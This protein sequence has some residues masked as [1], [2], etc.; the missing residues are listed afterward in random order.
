MENAQ[1]G[2]ILII[3]AGQAG[4]QIAETLRAEGYAGSLTLLGDEALPPYNR[5]PLSKE[6]LSGRLDLDK[7]PI[8]G[9]GFL[10]R[11]AIDWRGGAQVVAIDRAEKTVT[12]ADGSQLPYAGLALAT[13]ARL[14]RL[15]LPGADLPNVLGLR[16][17]D[18][19]QALAAALGRTPRVVVIGGGFIGLE[20]AAAARKRGCAVTVVEA[21]DRLLARVTAPLI[22]DYVAD[23][24]RRH[25]VELIF[26]AA[27]QAILER[28]GQACAVRLA[29]GRDLPADL[30]VYGVGVIA[31][32]TLAE[33][34]GL[35]CARGIL[36]DACGRTSDPAIVA[37]G[38]CTARRMAKGDPLRLESVQNAIEQGKAAACALLGKE[39]PFTAA[40][41]F[42]SDQFEM[43]LQMVGLSA[44]YDTVVTRG[45]PDEDAFSALYF[46]YN[47]LIAVDSINRA[48]EHMVARKLLDRQIR[49]NP[50]QA[51]DDSLSLAGLVKG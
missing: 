15:D 3:G 20:V 1:N 7:L 13:G 30:V 6:M 25:G 22:S 18:D 9:A 23:L 8:R 39:R 11:K 10:A 37:A 44:G 28:D 2:P 19:A 32:T 29:D 42:W 17:V 16:G 46:R 27:V 34:A 48:Q 24:H 47:K 12:L 49:L 50:I 36:V 31:Q 26:A 5:P 45:T 4:L 43:K 21:A 38:D 41:W 14:R 33:A 40:P 35:D 51:A